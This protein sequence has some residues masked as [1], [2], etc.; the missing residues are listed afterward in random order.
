MEAWIFL[1]LL[2]LAWLISPIILM[3]ALVV[4]RRQLHEL[5]QQTPASRG[6]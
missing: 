1:G 6:A 2:V 3:I 4:A 5:R